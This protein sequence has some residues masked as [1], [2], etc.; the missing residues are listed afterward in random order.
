MSLS[1]VLSFSR[2][3]STLQLFDIQV[4]TPKYGNTHRCKT[5]YAARI[6]MNHTQSGILFFPSFFKLCDL[7]IVSDYFDE[8]PLTMGARS[9]LLHSPDTSRHTSPL[10]IRD[11][12]R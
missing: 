3:N 10:R 1:P 12:L 2:R 4:C 9:F 11:I 8:A 7:L 6:K 5:M